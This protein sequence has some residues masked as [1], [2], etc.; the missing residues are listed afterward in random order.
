MAGS[1]A[2]ALCTL[3]PIDDKRRRIPNRTVNQMAPPSRSEWT[4]PKH[5]NSRPDLS[6]CA[7]KIIRKARDAIASMMNAGLRFYLETPLGPLRKI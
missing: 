5:E 3:V 4:P 7:K 1:G 2:V 6:A